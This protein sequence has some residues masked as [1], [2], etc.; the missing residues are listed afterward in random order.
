MRKSFDELWDVM[1]TRRRQAEAGEVPTAHCFDGIR[2]VQ[3]RGRG[4]PDGETL[5]GWA[6]GELRRHSLR[7]WLMVWQHVQIRRCRDCQTEVAALAAA[8]PRPRLRWLS[9]TSAMKRVIV[10]LRTAKTPLAWASSMLVIVVG[11]SL[12]SF[13]THN[14]F[15]TG[16]ER[17][18]APAIEGMPPVLGDELGLESQSEPIIWGD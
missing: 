10:S 4:C 18:G 1:E 7:R 2:G 8:G 6:D 17:S 14:T 11:L 3:R 12:W 9:L 16:M 15:Q 5:C 13:G